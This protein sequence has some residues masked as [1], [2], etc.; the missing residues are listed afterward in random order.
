MR[1]TRSNASLGDRRDAGLAIEVCEMR[2][3]LS[4]IFNGSYQR[5]NWRMLGERQRRCGERA[6]CHC[7][8]DE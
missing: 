2:L 4:M 1:M 8:S 6:G 3:Q 5:L 7:V